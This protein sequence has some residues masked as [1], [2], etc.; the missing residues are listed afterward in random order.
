[1]SDRPLSEE[2]NKLRST[3]QPAR[4]EAPRPPPQT[5]RRTRR[6]QHRAPEDD[7]G[8]A[9]PARTDRGTAYEKP[10]LSRR[11]VRSTDS[12]RDLGEGDANGSHEDG[13]HHEKRGGS[14][15]E[16]AVRQAA[17][18]RAPPARRDRRRTAYE[19]P[20]NRHSSVHS[21]TDS[22]VDVGE[23][24]GT[25]SF[26]AGGDS[27]VARGQAEERGWGSMDGA[28]FDLARS[29]SRTVDTFSVGGAGG[30]EAAAEFDFG[31]RAGR[32]V[33]QRA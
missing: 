29:R 28:L 8:A 24:D 4:R 32:R 26:G 3:L 22:Y 15:E 31:M 25:G 10:A 1:M 5:Q 18:G 19:K 16:G 17:G 9:P 14:R 7:D 20:L 11:S 21:S 2:E 6:R 30:N 12:S 13:S 27:C 23:G 33:S